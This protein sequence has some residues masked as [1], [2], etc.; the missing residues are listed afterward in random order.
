MAEIASET[1]LD[2]A[3]VWTL[4]LFLASIF[5]RAVYAKVRFPKEFADA[6]RGYQLVPENLASGFA[7]ALLA[8]ECA[9][10]PALLVSAAAPYAAAI[11]AGVLC[12]YALAI[13]INLLRGRRDIDCGC[14]GPAAR[15]T[16]HEMLVVR[17]LV[18]AAF[19]GF[20]AVAGFN[21]SARTL[22]WLD[23]M[24]IGLAVLCF[25]CLALALDQLAALAARSRTSGALS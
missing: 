19:A 22:I 17:N 18:Y 11:A 15:Q 10:V 23:G 16:L 8:L 3:L 13:G 14:S 20:A 9:L 2:P 25:I 12:L 4:R 5:A 7:G 21:T 6:L 1:V 24:T